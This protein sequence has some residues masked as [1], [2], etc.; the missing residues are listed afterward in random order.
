M[1]L[2]SSERIVEFL[3]NLIY[4]KTQLQKYGVD[5]TAK[6]IYVLEGPG[7]MDFGGGELE[8][9]NKRK[10]KLEKRSPTDKYG[11][12]NLPPGHYVL[13]Y[14]EKMNLKEGMLAVLQ[15]RMELIRNESYHPTMVLTSEDGLPIVTL[16][17]G[18]PGIKIKQNARVSRLLV[19][20]KT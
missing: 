19:F 5:L 1:G 4:E 17:V 18:P 13:E 10:F 6:E 3:E 20:E 8:F 9:A 7:S 2:L 11:W 14:N 15:P 16:S 12:W